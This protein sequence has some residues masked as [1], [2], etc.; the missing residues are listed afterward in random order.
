MADSTMYKSYQCWTTKCQ[1]TY[2]ME[3]AY[4][5]FQEVLFGQHGNGLM[6]FRNQPEYLDITEIIC[7]TDLLTKLQ[8]LM[9]AIL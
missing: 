1:S 6:K 9:S 7:I 5:P 2:L 3:R 4:L 8:Q